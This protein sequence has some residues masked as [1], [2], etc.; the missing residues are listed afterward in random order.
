MSALAAISRL[1]IDST[2]KSKP[3][4]DHGHSRIV[5]EEY[6]EGMQVHRRNLEMTLPLRE[7]SVRV[8]ITLSLPCRLSFRN[9]RHGAQLD[10]RK[11]P[12][13]TSP[14]LIEAGNVGDGEAALLF[15]PLLRVSSCI[16]RNGSIAI[17][18]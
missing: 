11:V 5:D 15:L 7:R 17:T 16:H 4:T 10:R 3:E 12:Y 14:F 18:R 1:L 9:A 2:V 8:S 6:T 13:F